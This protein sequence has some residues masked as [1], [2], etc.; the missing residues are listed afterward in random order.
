M[1]HSQNENNPGNAEYQDAFWLLTN[2]FKEWKE[3]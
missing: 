1:S 3:Y 2:K